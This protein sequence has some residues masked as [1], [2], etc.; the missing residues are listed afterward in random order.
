MGSKKYQSKKL[1]GDKQFDLNW[2]LANQH[3]S[4][5]TTVPGF[6]S[7]SIVRCVWRCIELTLE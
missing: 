6:S 7:G 2:L 3:F 4:L 1:K 5:V